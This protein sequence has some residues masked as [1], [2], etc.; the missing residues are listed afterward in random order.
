MSKRLEVTVVTMF[1]A[2]AVGGFAS[3]V[4]WSSPEPP[5][6]TP[7]V[8][9]ERI[10]TSVLEARENAVNRSSRT[11]DREEIRIADDKEQLRQINERIRER[12]EARREAR[13]EAR[14]EARRQARIAARQAAAQEQ[15]AE[16][17]QSQ[18]TTT[19]D[20]SSGTLTGVWRDLAMC[21]SGLNPRAYNPAGWYGLFQ[22]DL[23]TW[24]SVGGTGDPRDASVSEQ[25]MRA[26]TLQARSGWGPWPTC[27]AQLGLL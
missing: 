19:P 20:V 12:R 10:P 13:Q 22:F 4:A 6:A 25:L 16:E 1:V 26:Q 17:A 11:E 9:Q 23:G 24:Q 18:T 21:E 8:Q 2:V 14:Q 3:T 7:S 27:A 5:A 15:A